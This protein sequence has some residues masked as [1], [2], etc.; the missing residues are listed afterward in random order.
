[1]SDIDRIKAALPIKETVLGLTGLAMK[2]PHAEACPFCGGHGCFSFKEDVGGYHC[3]QCE[4][5]GDVIKF[6]EQHEGLSTGEAI[7]RAAK[8]AGIELSAAPGAAR[9]TKT[10]GQADAGPTV[11]DRIFS[12][13]ADYYHAKMLENGGKAYF[14]EKR[15]HTE[16]TLKALKVGYSDGKLLEHLRGLGYSDEEITGSGLVTTRKDELVDYF[17]GGLAIYPHHVQGKTVHFTCK[18]PLKGQ[19]PDGKEYKLQLQAK[20]R[21]PDWQFYNQDILYKRGEVIVVEGENDLQ[22]ILDAGVDNVI[23]LIGQPSDDQIKALRTHTSKK[24]LYLCLDNDLGALGGVNSTTGKWQD[25]FVRKIC[26]A[27][28]AEDSI[29]KIIILDTKSHEDGGVKDIDDYLRALPEGER[30]RAMKRLQEEALEPLAWEIAQAGRLPDLEA[31]H[32]RLQEQGVYRAVSEMSDLRLEIYLE[33]LDGLGFSRKAVMKAVEAENDLLENVQRYLGNLGKGDRADSHYMAEVVYKW[34][35]ARGKFF[36]TAD[37]RVYMYYRQTIYEIGNNLDFNTMMLKLTKLTPLGEPGKT[38]WHCL[39]CF[40]NDRGEQVEVMSW[41]H[42]NRE[43]DAVYI[44]L[45][46]PKNTIIKLMPNREPEEIPNGTNPEGVLLASSQKIQPFTFQQDADVRGALRAL[47]TLIF[48]NL[49]CE[50][51]V[52]YLVMT[53]LIYFIFIDFNKTRGLMKF[54]G[55]AASGKS[56]GAT[57]LSYLLYAKDLT[58]QSSAAASFSEGAQVPLIIQDNIENRDLNKQL[59]NFLLLGANSA[60]RSK[61]KGGTDSGVVTETIKALILITAIEPFPGTLPELISRTYEVIFEK[62]Y[63]H[64]GFVEDEVI[65]EIVKKRDLILSG[66]LKMAALEILPRLD[67]RSAW[68]SVLQ[69]KYAGHNKARTNEFLSLLLVILESLVK[70][71]PLYPEGHVAH[72]EGTDAADIL[73]GW[74]KYQNELANETA[75]TGNSILNFLDNIIRE[76]DAEMKAKGETLNQ[77]SHK[78]FEEQVFE[79][80]H[81]LYGLTVIKTKDEACTVHIENEDL[82]ARKKTFQFEASS[83]QLHDVINRYCKAVGTRNPYDNPTVLGCRIANDRQFI[84]K[85]GWQVVGKAD[86]TLHFKVVHGTKYFKF[87]KEVVY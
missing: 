75:T 84:E 28:A 53:W 29:I 26:K 74:I 44:N 17:F 48:N 34:F 62:R 22:S 16:R 24:H 31:K 45:N 21:H 23:G 87:R 6:L 4:A 77:V 83:A 36:K 59:V 42:T 79:H 9:P 49:A 27:L 35:S 25:G 82:P 58:G 8:L 43:I 5:A 1:M 70:Y 20:H 15:G 14:T 56:T 52:R 67:R 65:R 46:G 85:G 54:T 30:H 19:R 63:Q 32:K 73:E 78:D 71:I 50:R 12:A 61:R 47:E 60:P 69:L 55:P 57:L 40:C 39:Q 51:E 11:K 41:M 37:G 66:V 33:K 10:E 64:P 81:A 3:F 72:G 38:V 7:R 68:L 2:G 76:V 13:A 80:T 18:D 86:G